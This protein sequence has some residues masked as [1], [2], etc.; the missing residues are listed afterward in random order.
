MNC[1]LQ[2]LFARVLIRREKF[3]SKSSIIIPDEAAKR[4]APS[5]GTVVAV[6]PETSD[7]IKPGMTVLFGQYAGTWLNADGTV[8]AREQDAEFF[9][10]QD[11]D[12]IA[13]V[14]SDE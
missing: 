3:A 14:K 1:N 9:V 4:N 10:C 8:I 6:G 2:P 11:E 5:K 7:T 13:E 12:I